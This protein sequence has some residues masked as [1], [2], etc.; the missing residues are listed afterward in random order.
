MRPAENWTT[1]FTKKSFCRKSSKTPEN[2]DLYVLL[3]D[4]YYGRDNHLKA[5][6]AYEQAISLAGDH[7]RA[8]N[9]LAWLYA[10]TNEPDL[11]NPGLALTLAQRAAMLEQAPHVLDTLAECYFVNGRVADAI[12]AEQ[13]ALALADTK[14]RYYEEQLRRFKEA[15][16]SGEGESGTTEQRPESQ[17]P[18]VR[19]QRLV[20]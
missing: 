18:E 11:R 13:Q 1:I 10:T 12:Q 7:S 8:L 15:Y 19:G 9:N 16:L 20:H 5:S 14:R 2:T 17:K 3:G 4:L 6:Q